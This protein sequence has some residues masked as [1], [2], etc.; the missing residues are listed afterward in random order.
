MVARD[1]VA[2]GPPPLVSDVVAEAQ[3]R[4]CI[5]AQGQPIPCPPPPVIGVGG[6]PIDGAGAGCG[7]CTGWCGLPPDST[8]YVLHWPVGHQ[9]IDPRYVI[10]CDSEG[11]HI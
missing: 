4:V 6:M 9:G 1:M 10:P 7:V 2:A 11:V 8:H 5:G 3:R